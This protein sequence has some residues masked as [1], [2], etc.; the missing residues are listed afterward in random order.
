MENK[1]MEICKARELLDM[2]STGEDEQL[3]EM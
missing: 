3:I 2:I 1:R